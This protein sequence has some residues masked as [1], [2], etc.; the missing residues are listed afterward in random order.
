MLFV[1]LQERVAPV[2]PQHFER[3]HTGQSQADTG[4]W[5]LNLP[6]SVAGH[7]MGHDRVPSC[8]SVRY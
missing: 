7:F 1:T 3:I 6:R 8:E 5:D 2:H 4:V